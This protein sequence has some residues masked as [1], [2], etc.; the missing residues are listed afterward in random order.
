MYMYMYILNSLSIGIIGLL[1]LE[2]LYSG[3]EMLST[4]KKVIEGFI[5]GSVSASLFGSEE[6]RKNVIHSPEGCR[7]PVR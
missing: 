5:R 3:T 6:R 4:K 7:Y 1:K 2:K